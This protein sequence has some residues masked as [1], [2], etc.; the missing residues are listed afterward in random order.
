MPENTKGSEKDAILVDGYQV[1]RVIGS[2]CFGKVLLARERSS[3]ELF[4]IKYIPQY[5]NLSAALRTSVKRE[6]CLLRLLSHP[7]I[8]KIHQVIQ[9]PQRQGNYVAVVMQYASNGDLYSYVTK[10]GSVSEYLARKWMRQIVSALT[11]CQENC[12][13]HRDIKPENI[14]VDEGGNLM[15]IDFG[16]ANLWSVHSKMTTFCGSPYY[17]APEVL[18]GAA[19]RGPEI[20][21]WSLGVTFYVLLTATL[22]FLGSDLSELRRAQHVP[23]ARDGSVSNDA[24]ELLTRMLQI[25]P[26][27][28]ITVEEMH[29]HPWMGG[30][31]ERYSLQRIYPFAGIPDRSAVQYVCRLGYTEESVRGAL[32]FL[33]KNALAALYH[34]VCENVLNKSKSSQPKQSPAGQPPSTLARS[35]FDCF[36]QKAAVQSTTTK[37]AS[38]P[39]IKLVV[40]WGLFAYAAK[41][42]SYEGGVSN[43]MDF[44]KK[45]LITH[46][47]IAFQVVGGGEISCKSDRSSFSILVK[48]SK[49]V[50]KDWRIQFKRE[51]GPLFGIR[52]LSKQIIY[53]LRGL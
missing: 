32:E 24:W 50:A 30:G 36:G 1:Q 2:G 3:N 16:F 19:Y 48:R 46:T 4:A 27:Q 38:Q 5:S 9:K 40:Q 25:D 33:E 15:L 29:R 11:Y 7:N 52:S 21:I 45:I 51:K 31:F 41:C 13:V 42:L 23:L 20:D 43:L 34:L 18:T 44:L 17:A 37:P 10:N 8:I 53:E 14:L 49:S 35:F 26:N 22:P 47:E 28:R 39:A 12:L 6:V